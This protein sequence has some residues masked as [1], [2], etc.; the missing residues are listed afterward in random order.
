MQPELVDRGRALVLELIGPLAA[1]LVLRVFP[2]GTDPFLEEMVVGFKGE[3][4]RGS[5]VVLDSSISWSLD[6][7]GWR[8][9]HVDAP[10]F[11]DRIKSDDLFEEIIPVVALT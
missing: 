11:F 4:G 5:N 8:P 7:S 2:F 9:A 6:Q 10:E 1:M 3:L